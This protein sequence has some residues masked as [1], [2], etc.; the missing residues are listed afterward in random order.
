[1]GKAIDI[2]GQRFGQWN[3]LERAPARANRHAYWICQCD[4]GKISE[5]AGM[6]LRNGS[7]SGCGCQKGNKISQKNR[8]DL[9]GQRFGKLTALFQNTKIHPKNNG[10]AFWHC[11]C[12]CGNETDVQVSY[13]QDGEI[14]SCGCINYSIGEKNIA[15]ILEQN[16]ISFI[17]EYKFIDLPRLRYDFFLPD[18]NR[19]VEFD[20]KQHY[21]SVNHFGGENEYII[22]QNNDAK[23]NKYAL[24]HD[25]DL[26][27]IPYWERD[28]INLNM[29]L[30]DQYLYNPI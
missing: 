6:A 13:L 24:E 15:D 4:C 3:V 8:L 20:G 10:G 25:I 2:I 1:M 9:T 28:N 5:I 17:K 27:R 22:R 30:G 18:Y 21:E 26:V 29:I 11:K 7:S 16:S 14:Q 23:K 12:D 19:L